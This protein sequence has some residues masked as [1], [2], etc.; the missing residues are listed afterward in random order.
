MIKARCPICD[1]VMHG[2]ELREF[3][4][5]PFCSFRCKRIDLGR[6]LGEQYRVAPEPAEEEAPPETSDETP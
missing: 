3:P 2:Q 4:H 6:W 1:K 5:F